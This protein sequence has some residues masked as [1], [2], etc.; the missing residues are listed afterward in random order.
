MIASAMLFVPMQV[1]EPLSP[2]ILP[3]Q[4]HQNIRASTLEGTPS[5]I[6]LDLALNVKA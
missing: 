5:E 2:L 4:H 3:H 6:L 1:S